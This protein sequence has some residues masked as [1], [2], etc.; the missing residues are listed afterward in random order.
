MKCF[1]TNPINI[2]EL[3]EIEV[4]P[5]S[6]MVQIENWAAEMSEDPRNNRVDYGPPPPLEARKPD[7]L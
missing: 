6:R 4:S 5:A 7:S 1:D 3:P 2:P